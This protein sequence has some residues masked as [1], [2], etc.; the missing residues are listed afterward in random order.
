MWYAANAMHPNVHQFNKQ[1]IIS[2]R[3]NKHLKLSP[4]N[5]F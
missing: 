2:K 1:F 4:Y 5:P 3:T